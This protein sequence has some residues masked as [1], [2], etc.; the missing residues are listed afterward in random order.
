MGSRNAVRHRRTSRRPSSSSSSSRNAS[1][2][3][4]P[5]DYIL[6]P[7]HLHPLRLEDPAVLVLTVGILDRL[8]DPVAD[9]SG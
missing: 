6:G 3:L 2:L 9:W 5:T 4:Q 8:L 7:L 1:R